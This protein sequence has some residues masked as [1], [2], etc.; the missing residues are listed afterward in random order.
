MTNIDLIQLTN[1]RP[2]GL[3]EMSK[4]KKTT[5]GVLQNFKQVCSD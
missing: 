1:G 2:Q 4:E 5:H 3:I